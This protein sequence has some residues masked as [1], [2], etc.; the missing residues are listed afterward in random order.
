MEGSWNDL[1]QADDASFAEFYSKC[2]LQVLQGTINVKAA[3][4]P[5]VI[6]REYAHS[7]SSATE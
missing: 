7:N 6:I 4:P 1:L 5:A 2:W 3:K